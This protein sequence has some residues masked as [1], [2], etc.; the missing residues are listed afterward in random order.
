MEIRTGANEL[1]YPPAIVTLE[2]WLD[3]EAKW[4]SYNYLNVT[5]PIKHNG[6]LRIPTPIQ[7]TD[8]C[9]GISVHSGGYWVLVSRGDMTNIAYIEIPNQQDNG[10]PTF[11]STIDRTINKVIKKKFVF[12]AHP[13]NV[14]SHSSPVI[15]FDHQGYLHMVCGAHVGQLGYLKCTQIPGSIETWWTD[16]PVKFAQSAAYVTLFCDSR[17]T[18]HSIYRRHLPF[19][20]SLCYRTMSAST[21]SQWLEPVRLV[22]APVGYAKYDIYYHLFI[23]RK[24][25]LYLAFTFFDVDHETRGYPEG[26]LVSLDG[27][28][29]WSR[30][31]TE[32]SKSRITQKH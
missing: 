3:H 25:A 15:S 28:K 21:P 30:A 12:N 6:R 10:N 32:I 14:D 8:R 11:I 22:R 2:K 31:T 27:G 1:E 29:N 13:D 7:I 5:L 19:P 26:L 4:G 9:S 20:T 23:D 16:D 17:N 18:L 24:D